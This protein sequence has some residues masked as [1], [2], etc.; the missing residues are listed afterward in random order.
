MCTLASDFSMSKAV[1]NPIVGSPIR[2]TSAQY[3]TVLGA[4]LHVLYVGGDCFSCCV[5]FVERIDFRAGI[6]Q[7][8]SEDID[9]K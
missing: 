8:G 1:G 3:S 5:E 7:Y 9:N 6:K 4:V 2:Y